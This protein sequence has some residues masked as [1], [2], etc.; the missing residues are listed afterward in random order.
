MGILNP[1]SDSEKITRFM[2][3]EVVSAFS[4]RVTKTWEIRA[5]WRDFAHP[6]IRASAVGETPREG[7]VN[8]AGGS[9]AP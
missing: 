8:C 2:G 9:S 3:D 5:L 1:V 6:P 7:P 4:I